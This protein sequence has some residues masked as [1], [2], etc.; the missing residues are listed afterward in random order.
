MTLLLGPIDMEWKGCESSIH[1]HNIGLC[2]S[3]LEVLD[4]D[5]GDFGMLS[6]Y[7]VADGL[8]CHYAHVLHVTVMVYLFQDAPEPGP[9][10]KKKR[11]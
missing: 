1:D 10:N 4:S 9:S 5:R 6:T 3:W 11:W 2:A 7:L 8:K